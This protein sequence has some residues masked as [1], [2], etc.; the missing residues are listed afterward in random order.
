MRVTQKQL[1]FLVLSRE[2]LKTHMLPLSNSS[3]IVVIEISS[4]LQKGAIID[5][6]YFSMEKVLFY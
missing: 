1:K 5:V 3:I 6:V 4:E 2:N